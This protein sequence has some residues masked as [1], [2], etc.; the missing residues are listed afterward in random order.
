[1]SVQWGLPWSI[2]SQIQKWLNHQR[3]GDGTKAYIGNF[4]QYQPS[5]G[6]G[7]TSSPPATP[8]RL[9]NP[10]WPLGGPKMANGFWKGCSHQLLLNKLFD[11]STLSMRKGCD[12]GNGK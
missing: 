7:G 3:E 2:Y 4:L 9:Q 12:K 11:P 6:A 5:N 10:I 1:M 8:H